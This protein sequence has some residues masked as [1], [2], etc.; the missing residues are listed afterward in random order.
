MLPSGAFTV[1][2]PEGQPPGV[3]MLRNVFFPG[4]YIAIRKNAIHG[5]VSREYVC[6]RVCVLVCVCVCVHVCAW[7]WCVVCVCV[8]VCGCM[9]LCD[10]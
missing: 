10:S 5:D 1:V 2:V 4:C 3:I 8:C 6:T 9:H 7:V